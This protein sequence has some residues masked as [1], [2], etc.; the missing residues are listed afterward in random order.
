MIAVLVMLNNFF[1]DFAV[2]C[3]T[4]SVLGW[5]AVWSA[6]PEAG[7][8]ARP[9]VARLDRLALR[10]MF[11]SLA[12]VVLFGTVRTLA[13]KE[14]EWLPAAGRDQVPALMVKHALLGS[15][16]A[17]AAAWAVRARK[18]ASVLNKERTGTE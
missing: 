11:A 1:H 3:L 6:L 4:C 13:F 10:A 15:L 2:A 14:Y 9:I 7:E 8:V 17:F 12:G 16:L 18:R 5:G